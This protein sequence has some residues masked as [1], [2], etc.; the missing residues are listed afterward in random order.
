MISERYIIKFICYKK[1]RP[2]YD[3]HTSTCICHIIFTPIFILK[4][5]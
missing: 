5:T 3:S 4:K 2:L 1:F